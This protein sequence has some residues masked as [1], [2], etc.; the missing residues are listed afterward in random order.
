MTC[1]LLPNALFSRRNGGRQ[2][3]TVPHLLHHRPATTVR[4][5][6]KRRDA[7]RLINL[8]TFQTN[9]EDLNVARNELAG[10]QAKA[11]S[12]IYPEDVDVWVLSLDH[13]QSVAH[14]QGTLTP[15]PSDNCCRQEDS[16]LV[17]CFF[18]FF[19][20]LQLTFSLN[21]IYVRLSALGVT[22]C[23][24]F[25]RGNG[26]FEHQPAA[27]WMPLHIC[28][29]DVSQRDNRNKKNCQILSFSAHISKLILIGLWCPL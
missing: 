21:R 27:C 14:R 17:Q 29:T 7:H 1:T 23:W 18:F 4:G 19:T 11:F 16:W 12:E 2:N 6:T 20:I 9:K 3:E 15:P 10:T 28:L 24:Y 8:Q 25:H 5:N 26:C 13:S 22:L